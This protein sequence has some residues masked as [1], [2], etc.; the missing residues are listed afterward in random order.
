MTE[1]NKNMITVNI[2]TSKLPANANAEDVMKVIEVSESA[3][4]AKVETLCR[5]AAARAGVIVVA[6]LLGTG[7]LIVN[8]LYLVNRIARL[9]NRKL[10]E[11]AIAAFLGAVGGTIAGNLLTTLIPLSVVQIPVAVGITYAVGKVADVWIKDGMPQ[12]MS[13]YKPMLEEWME[14]AKD[15]AKDIAEDP[16]KNVP[17][18]DE[19]KEMIREKAAKAKEVVAEKVDEAKVRLGEVKEQAA[20]KIDEA[21][22]RLG[23]VKEQATEKAQEVKEKATEKAQE[24]KEKAVEKAQVVTEKASEKV[25]EVKAKA[26]EKKE[27]VVEKAEE[28]KEKVETK[29]DEVKETTENKN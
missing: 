1:E 24:V 28:V 25:Q 5:W 3:V 8:E 10:N 26:A 20:E 7:A 17:L 18:G 29:V 13:K 14:K 27:E 4:D 12:D 9:Y 15:I 19:K 22:V 21:K 16:L 2:D 23:E 6:P 11:R